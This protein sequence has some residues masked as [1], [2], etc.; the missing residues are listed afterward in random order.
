MEL[1]LL[2]TNLHGEQAWPLIAALRLAF[3]QMLLNCGNSRQGLNKNSSLS[4][5]HWPRQSASPKISSLWCY[6]LC[7]L[8]SISF[9]FLVLL[10]L[11]QLSQTNVEW[12]HLLAAMATR[13]PWQPSYYPH[14]LFYLHPL[15][16]SI[17]KAVVAVVLHF[18]VVVEIWGLLEM[19]NGRGE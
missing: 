15:S 3:G 4:L 13:L 7:R 9:L 8:G 14:V 19:L 12:G 6:V 5:T 10:L 17:G 11:D 2:N 16:T 18:V 1:F